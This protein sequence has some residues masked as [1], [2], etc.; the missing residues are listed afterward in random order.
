MIE[1]NITVLQLIALILMSLDYLSTK[2]VIRNY[3]KIFSAILYLLRKNGKNSYIKSQKNIKKNK[4]TR[5]FKFFLFFIVS[6]FFSFF[7]WFILGKATYSI[8][9]NI[10]FFIILLGFST[11]ML[12][13]MNALDP[14]IQ[15]FTDNLTNKFFNLPYLLTN[16]FPQK[17]SLAIFGLLIL[18][19]SFLL[20]LL[21]ELIFLTKFLEIISL[22]SILFLFMLFNY[23]IDQLYKKKIYSKNIHIIG[24]VFFIITL[25]ISITKL[26]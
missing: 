6:T 4:N 19:F 14:Y 12:T 16:K 23:F 24:G 1:F 15:Y 9:Y 11:I 21:S 26:T 22:F 18:I 25:L 5:I 3:D 13:F 10:L 8:N 20:K 2:N 7:I 17:G